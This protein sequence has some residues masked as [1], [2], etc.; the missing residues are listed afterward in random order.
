[1]PRGTLCYQKLYSKA[2]I[3]PQELVDFDVE[4]LPLSELNN[5]FN[6]FGFQITSMA[7][8]STGKWEQYVLNWSG[9]KD[10]IKLSQNKEDED[11]KNWI[12]LWYDMYFKYRRPY[13]GQAM[14]GLQQILD[15]NI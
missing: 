3:P 8:D 5:I 9:K 13:E 15:S 4:V 1:M 10:L 2:E 12:K 14:F 11:L 7:S 6:Q